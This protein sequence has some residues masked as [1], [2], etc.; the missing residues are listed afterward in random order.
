[1]K[2]QPEKISNLT[3]NQIDQII[4][5]CTECRDVMSEIAKCSSE[6]LQ[7]EKYKNITA[8]P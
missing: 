6:L 8:I 7:Q 5:Q 4:V 1:M 2:L 3:E